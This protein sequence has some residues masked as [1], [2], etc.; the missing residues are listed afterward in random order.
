MRLSR[1]LAF[2]TLFCPL[3]CRGALAADL[4]LSEIMAA[5]TSTIADEDGDFSDWIEVYNAGPDAVNLAGW[6]LTDDPAAPAKW[7][8]PAITIEPNGF[9]LVFASDKDRRDPL[10]RLHANFKLSTTGEYLALLDPA[11]D[12]AWE[13][14]FYPPQVEE[15]SYGL[16]QNARAAERLVRAGDPARVLIPSSGALGLQWTE[17]VFNDA[18]WQAGTTGVGYD[19]NPDYRSLIGTDV[20]STMDGVSA[21][22]YIRIPFTVADPAKI[23][24]LRLRVKYDD[25]FIAYVNGTRVGSR[26]APTTP[27]WSST[28]TALNDDGLAVVFEEI[29]IPGAA[30][31]LRSGTNVLAI[32][33]L[34]DNTGSSDFLIVPELDGLDSGTLDRTVIEYFPQPSPGHG[35]FAGVPGIAEKPWILPENGI[36]TGNL[37]VTLGSD[38]PGGV[39]RYTLDG[40]EPTGASAAYSTAIS[41]SASTMVRARVFEPD[42]SVSPTTSAAYIAIASSLRDFTSDL[43]VIIIDNLG[44]GSVPSNTYQTAFMAIFEPGTGRTSL[45]N[46]PNLE[47]RIGMKLRGSSTEGT[48]K[49]SFAIEARDDRNEDK[50][51]EPLGL[52]AE[53]DWI[54]HAPYE[55]DRA[56]IR[57]PLIYELSNQVG[58]YAVRTRFAE[59]YINREGGSLSSADYAGVYSFMEKIKRGKDRVDVE[60]LTPADN[61]EPR[62]QGGYMLKIDRRDPGDSG[63]SAGGQGLSYVDPKEKDVTAAQASWIRDYINR[64]VSALNG[65]AFTDPV[66]GYAPFIDA[67]SWIEHH[68]LNVL[69]KNVDALRLSTYFYKSREGGIEFGPIWDFDRSMD[70]TDGRDDDPRTWD[71]TGDGT[72]YF[73]YTWWGRLFEDPEFWQRYRD[74]WHVL[75]QG[76]LK[77]TNIHAVIDSM[78]AELTEAQVRDSAK[79]NRVSP[80]GWRTEITRVKNWLS[81]RGSWIDSQ[82]TTPPVFN[83]LGGA[84]SIGFQL[85]MSAPQGTIHYTLDGTDPRLRGGGTA[86]GAVPYTGAV[87]LDGNARVVA[88]AR[89]SASNWS[90]AT[91]ATFVVAT[92]ELV[93]T[94]IMYHPADPPFGS[95]QDADDFEFIELKNTGGVPITLAGARLTEGISFTFPATDTDPL[96]PGEIVLVVKDMTA[97]AERYSSAGMRIAGE[98]TGRLQNAGERLGLEG[99]LGE[100][101]LLFDYSEDWQPTTDGEGDSLVILDPTRDFSTWGDAESWA[102]SSVPGGTPGEDD[103]GASTPGGRQLPADSNQDGVVDISDGLS[104]LL[105]LFLGN[106]ALPCEGASIEEG[107]NAVL[108]DANGDGGVNVADVIYLLGY[109][110]QEGPP[111]A[112]G[113]RCTRIEGCPDACG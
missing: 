108:L 109:L 42:L 104:L 20:R 16:R 3:F 17:A 65:A 32:H 39:I 15:F 11:R 75:R 58:R 43:P 24:A 44:A 93:I 33:G 41:I 92:P 53:S 63:F 30:S 82:F 85:T 67:D 49:Q 89:I 26:N 86:P 59:V 112:A 47:T 106:P 76:P 48:P 31:I 12:I 52:P 27:T 29:S 84:I 97:F 56:L 21:S 23:P 2:L 40:T 6:S 25:G 111:P 98:Y 45:R 51:V 71:G 79:W 62:I 10:G 99:P 36:F 38:S 70:S 72:G 90:A 37:S 54:L 91:A 35:N 103:P 18:A 81:T 107:G 96:G 22:C 78:A 4:V 88:R 73:G 94:E 19:R 80:A 8:F 34:N 74:R 61:S 68:I 66:R 69:P 77:T 100:P 28:A 113:T 101:I 105:R 57:N 14:I 110:F 83:K 64:F 95:L 13:Y 55:F 102:A 9:L 46:A 60:N 87:T 7:Q 5:N 1:T 50:D